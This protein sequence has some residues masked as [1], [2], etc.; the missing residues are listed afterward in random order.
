M[1]RKMKELRHK[2]RKRERLMTRR[3][4]LALIN[5]RFQFSRTLISEHIAVDGTS[6]II[7]KEEVT[8]KKP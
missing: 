1:G 7:E 2:Q 3:S 8:I 6:G 4:Q 5:N